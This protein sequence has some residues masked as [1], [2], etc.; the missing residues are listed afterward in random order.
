VGRK[1]ALSLP[2]AAVR[3]DKPSPYVQQVI[4]GR[5]AHRPVETGLR[6]QVDGQAM[7][8]VSGIDEG[9][10]VT[11]GSV[12]SLRDGTAVRLASGIAP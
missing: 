11:A 12:G 10:L 9:A 6:G 8:A 4:N 7:V 1:Q 5:V 2:L 3:I